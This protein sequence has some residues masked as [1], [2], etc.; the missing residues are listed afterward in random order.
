MEP[1]G[2]LYNF[3]E[4]PANVTVAIGLPVELMG[5]APPKAP[6]QTMTSYDAEPVAAVPVNKS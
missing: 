1:L 5:P 6:S 4:V 3:H 2:P